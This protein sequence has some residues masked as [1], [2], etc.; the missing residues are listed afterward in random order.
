MGGRCP[1]T[2]CLPSGNPTGK[3]RRLMPAPQDILARLLQQQLGATYVAGS[4]QLAA[5]A[6][7]IAPAPG[8]AAAP[9]PS[10]GGQAHL[11]TCTAI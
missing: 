4:L 8:V 6:G 11:R 2:P 10:T 7:I 3:T 9:A 5:S 1:V